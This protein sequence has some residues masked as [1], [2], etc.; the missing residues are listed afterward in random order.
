MYRDKVQKIEAEELKDVF[1]KDTNYPLSQ[2]QIFSLHL[3][4]L[5]ILKL[6]ALCLRKGFSCGSC[7]VKDDALF[8][9]AM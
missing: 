9:S 3:L 1:S 5:L 7:S 8:S 2:E 6:K 4:E